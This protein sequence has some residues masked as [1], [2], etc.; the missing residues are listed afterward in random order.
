[1]KR[2]FQLPALAC[3]LLGGVTPVATA[4]EADDAGPDIPEATYTAKSP[5]RLLA[6]TGAN[7]V[8][9][10]STTPDQ[11][12]EANIVVPAGQT[13]YLVATFSGESYCSGPLGNW[14]SLHVMVD[15]AEANPDVFSDFAFDAASGT[16]ADYWESHS[17]QRISNL[18][19]AGTHNVEVHW[20]VVGSG[21]TTFRLDDWLF[22]VEFW[23]NN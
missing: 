15:G 8:T 17:I 7:A 3:L 6:K 14:C 2:L 4:Q 11:L 16:G 23:R 19:G 22:K 12:T 1:M 10:Q 13:G 18:V 20:F 21:T 9:T 5:T